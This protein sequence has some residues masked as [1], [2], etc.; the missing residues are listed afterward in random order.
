MK[1]VQ[2]LV[3]TQ[4]LVTPAQAAHW[5]K[6][7]NNANR[8]FSKSH[9]YRFSLAMTR[10][11]WKTTQDTISFELPR[12][13][14]PLCVMEQSGEIMLWVEV[15]T[16]PGATYEMHTFHVRGTGNS[17]VGGEDE[18]IGSVQVGPFVWHVYE[19]WRVG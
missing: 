17:F 4:E 6:Y 16:G 13:S 12:D 10:G 9:M 2:N 8:P 11:A 15:T 3:F 14:V 7:N 19:D 5:L 18:Y 1:K